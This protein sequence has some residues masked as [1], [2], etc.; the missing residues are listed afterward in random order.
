MG[1]YATDSNASTSLGDSIQK[2]LGSMQLRS[3]HSGALFF[4]LLPD[5]VADKQFTSVVKRDGKVYTNGATKDTNIHLYKITP[6]MPNSQLQEWLSAVIQHAMNCLPEREKPA[7]HG[8]ILDADSVNANRDSLQTYNVLCPK[9]HIG[10]NVFDLVD[11][12][13]HCLKDP[14]L[15]HVIGQPILSPFV[16]RAT[17]REEMVQQSSAMR[18]HSD[19]MLQQAEQQGNE[20]KAEQLRSHIFIGVGSTIERYVKLHG[21]TK[22]TEANFEAWVFGNYWKKHQWC[23][24]EETRNI[25]LSGEYVWNEY[26]QTPTLADWAAPAIQYCRALENEIKR[27]IY[28][29]YPQSK[30]LYSDVGQKGFDRHLTLGAL[31]TICKFK[32]E[33]HLYADPE[34]KKKIKSAKHNWPLCKAIVITS[35]SDIKAFEDILRCMVT[36]NVSY[37]RNELAHGGPIPQST[38]QKLRDAILG[39][40]GKIGILCWLVEYLEPKK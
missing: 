1:S 28:D 27:R 35:Q 9:P 13:K 34:D 26:Q 8:V 30:E 7:C 36:E 21:D 15:C 33:D 17:T 16:I 38:A 12:D 4:P 29:Y 14:H 11:R 20:K 6:D 3:A 18:I 32:D 2:I 39:Y 40:K 19:E 22:T 5:P 24:S 31:E 10:K 37:N 25:L 23:L